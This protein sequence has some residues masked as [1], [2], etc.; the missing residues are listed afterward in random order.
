M[1]FICT[2][3]NTPQEVYKDHSDPYSDEVFADDLEPHILNMDL[4]GDGIIQKEEFEI[5]LRREIMPISNEIDVFYDWIQ[6][7]LSS[8]PSFVDPAAEK[9]FK[10]FDSNCDGFVS[11]VYP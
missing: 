10:E 3:F 6:T 11:E 1:Y 4:T 2:Y 8:G 7:Y 5:H 9:L